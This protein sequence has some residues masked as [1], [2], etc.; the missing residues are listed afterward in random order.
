MKFCKG[1]CEIPS[2]LK[3]QLQLRKF[4]PILVNF[5]PDPFSLRTDQHVIVIH[6]REHNY[7][8][9]GLLLL[10]SSYI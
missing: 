5:N 6:Q 10:I 2:N 4:P 7:S 9:Q 3:A 8:I 1:I